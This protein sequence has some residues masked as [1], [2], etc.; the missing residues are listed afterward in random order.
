MKKSMRNI[1]DLKPSP[2]NPRLISEW[3]LEALKKSLA[4]FGDLSGIVFNRTSG[5]LVGGHQRVKVFA[6]EGG[7]VTITEK[8]PAPDKR[9]T[10]ALGWVEAGGARHSYREVEWDETT[11]KAANIAANKHGGEFDNE[12]LSEILKELDGKIQ[13][14]LLGFTQEDIEAIMKEVAPPA[15][16]KEVDENV[17]TEFTCPKCGFEWS[18]KQGVRK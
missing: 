15:D 10:V 3:Q 6:E 13:V 9:G 16:F 8:M 2:A 11:E 5:H 1:S 14:D 7:T 18:G 12:V 4:K 17:A